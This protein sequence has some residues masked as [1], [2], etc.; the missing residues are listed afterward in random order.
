MSSSH[1]LYNRI[2]LTLRPLVAVS[3]IKQLNN[4]LKT[5]YSAG[6]GSSSVSSKRIPWHSAR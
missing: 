1:E 4:G 2:F 3:N 5:T 6:C